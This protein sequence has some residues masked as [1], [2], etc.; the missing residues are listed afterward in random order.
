MTQQF[1][2]SIGLPSLDAYVV[3]IGDQSVAVR[4]FYE[5]VLRRTDDKLDELLESFVA[6]FNDSTALTLAANLIKWATSALPGMSEM[7]AARAEARQA[8]GD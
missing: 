1:L 5:E 4:S 3:E 7:L 8:K 2:E 6:V